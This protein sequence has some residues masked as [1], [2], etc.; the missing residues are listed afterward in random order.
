M[1]ITDDDRFTGRIQV[2]GLHG[3][4]KDAWK[5]LSDEGYKHYE[6]SALRA[7]LINL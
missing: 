3:M 4:S 7:N 6:H 2:L 1:V 5:R